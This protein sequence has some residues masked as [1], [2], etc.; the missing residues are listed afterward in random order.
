MPADAVDTLTARW[1]ATGPDAG[2]VRADLTALTADL[3]AAGLLLP[4]H[5]PD[6]RETPG[7]RL[8]A[9]APA[10]VLVLS[11]ART[12]DGPS[13]VV[14]TWTRRHGEHIEPGSALTGS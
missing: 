11:L 5:Q 12:G 8:A 1:E 10:G 4:A 2:Q 6:Q 9:A 14:K 7:A 13:R 3:D